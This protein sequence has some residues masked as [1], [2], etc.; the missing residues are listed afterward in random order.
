MLALEAASAGVAK[1]KTAKIAA[2]M[3]REVRLDVSPN[4]SSVRRILA[5]A[6]GA[7]L[8]KS[9]RSPKGQ[10]AWADQRLKPIVGVHYMARAVSAR[11]AALA[12]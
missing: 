10:R 1:E 2:I 11:C 6:L 9:L 5:A 4:I 3:V 7:D 8:R 12:R